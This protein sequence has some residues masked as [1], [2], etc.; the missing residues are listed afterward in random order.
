LKL[1]TNI[2]CPDGELYKFINGVAV[3]PGMRSKTTGQPV[4]IT[5]KEFHELR[6]LRMDGNGHPDQ[7]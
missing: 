1:K 6:K 5:L 4:T 3:V 7:S 2:R